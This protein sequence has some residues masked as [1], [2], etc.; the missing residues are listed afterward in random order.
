MD[1]AVFFVG[2]P[3]VA[4]LEGGNVYVE[5]R[6]GARIFCFEGPISVFIATFRHFAEVAGE[7]RVEQNG[8]IERIDHWRD[9]LHS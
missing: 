9:Q 6:S 3:P 4:K 5:V 7:W 2:E 8:K 1:N